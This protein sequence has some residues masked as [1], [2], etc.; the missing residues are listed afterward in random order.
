MIKTICDAMSQEFYSWEL[1]E[2]NDDK[3]NHHGS[4]S[5]RFYNYDRGYESILINEK[6]FVP[7]DNNIGQ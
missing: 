5:P 7:F 3:V 6:D 2:E 4:R 1:R